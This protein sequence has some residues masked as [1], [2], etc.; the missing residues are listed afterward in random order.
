MNAKNKF[1]LASDVGNIGTIE[2]DRLINEQKKNIVK[3]DKWNNIALSFVLSLRKDVFFSVVNELQLSFKGKKKISFENVVSFLKDKDYLESVLID[4][5]MPCLNRDINSLGVNI[6]GLVLFNSKP[7]T[8]SIFK[9]NS[10]QSYGKIE[11]TNKEIVKSSF[12]NF[13]EKEIVVLLKENELILYKDNN[14]EYT[15]IRRFFDVVNYNCGMIDQ[16]DCLIVYHFDG[17][18]EF[19]VK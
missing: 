4:P 11:A 16:K 2:I 12:F 5:F 18:V 8:T 10:R 13:F 14:G 19:F 7:D 15:V 6:K 1:L 3:I 9:I 17:R